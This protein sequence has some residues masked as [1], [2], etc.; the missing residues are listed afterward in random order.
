MNV[1]KL[2][3]RLRE[4]ADAYYNG[5]PILSDAAFD[6]LEAELRELDPNHPVLLRIG[7]GAG[8]TDRWRR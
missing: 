5:E 6:V 3:N 8:D 7:A 4:A 2:A 1:E